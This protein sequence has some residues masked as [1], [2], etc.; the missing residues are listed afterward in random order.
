MTSLVKVSDVPLTPSGQLFLQPEMNTIINCAVGGKNDMDTEA[1]KSALKN[2]IMTK[3]PRFSSLLVHDKNGMEHW[4][5]TEVDVNKHI[6]YAEIPKVNGTADNNAGIDAEKMVNDYIADLSVSSPLSLD[7]P[8]WEIHILPEPRCAVFRCHHALGDGIELMSMFLG[9]CRKLED[10]EAVPTLDSGRI[11]RNWRGS[12]G[13]LKGRRGLLMWFLKMVLYA[14]NFLM[15][16]LK[17][18]FYTLLFYVEFVLRC[19]WVGDSKTVISGGDGVE[20]WPRKVATA[21][22]LIEDM[23]MVKKAVANATINDVLLGMISAGFSRYLDHRSPNSLKKNQRLTGVAMVNLK[24]PITL[25]DMDLNK[26]IESTPRSRK[27]NKFGIILIPIFY[28]KGIAPLQYVKIAKRTVDRKKQ[29]LEAFISYGISNLSNYLFGSKFVSYFMYRILCH[30]SFTISNMAG[31][32][33][34]VTLAGNPITYIKA[35]ITGVPQAVAM[36]MVSYAGKADMQL[37]VAKDII[38]DP[39]FLAKCLEDSL[40]EMKEA[41]IATMKKKGKKMLS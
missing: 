30:S 23:K 34:Q 6:I 8:L 15:G 1:I 39:Q 19:F 37:V 35:N 11:R 40:L 36:H 29:S 32:K 9:S 12:G 17:V 14:L 27:G 18:V 24:E 38:P 20:L 16:F 41:A 21:H 10:P 7:K 13:K 26:M 33:D 3:H 22:F 28:N 31:P 4:R 25:Q 5:R 2:S